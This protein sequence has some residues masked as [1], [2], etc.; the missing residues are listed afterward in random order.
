[1]EMFLDNGLWV[2][3][4]PVFGATPGLSLT[5]G[6]VFGGTSAADIDNFLQG[7]RIQGATFLPLPVLPIIGVGGGLNHSYGGR[8]ASEFGV[9]IPPGTSVNPL[10]YGFK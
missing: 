5:V 7:A 6:N 10:S 2:G 3:N 8:T 4:T 1:M 9:S